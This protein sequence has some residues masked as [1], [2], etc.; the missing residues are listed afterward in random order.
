MVDLLGR[1]GHL[2]QAVKF[3]ES[4][5][6]KPDISI[7]SSL[8]RACGS[9]QNIELAEKVF[10]QL[11]KIDPIN[12]AAYALISNIYAK[13]GRWD[14][15][16]WARKKLHELRVRKQPGCSLIEQNGVVHE[17]TAWDFSN[18]QSAEIYAMLDEIKGRLQKQDLVET[19]SHHSERLVVA[20]GLLNNP[21]RTPI[22]VVNNL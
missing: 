22:C 1:A 6:I 11:I 21:P 17:F 8:L 18:P 16:S 13:A 12:D 19:S 20:F 9:H 7:W 14:D 4:M 5:P 10:Q 15:V 2:D 3:I